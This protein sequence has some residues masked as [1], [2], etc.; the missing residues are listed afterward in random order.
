MPRDLVAATR[1]LDRLSAR[2]SYTLIAFTILY[3]AGQGIRYLIQSGAL[4]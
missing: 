1:R 4:S 2:F 3:F